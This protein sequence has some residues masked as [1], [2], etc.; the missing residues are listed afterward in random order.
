VSETDKQTEA[1]REREGGRERRKEGRRVFFVNP[2]NKPNDC[3]V[4]AL[5]ICTLKQLIY[6][7][8]WTFSS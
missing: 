7:L 1:E 2:N 6:V 5:F 4:L 3:Y 8:G